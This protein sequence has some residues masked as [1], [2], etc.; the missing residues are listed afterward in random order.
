MLKKLFHGGTKI[1][2]PIEFTHQIHIDKDLN[3]SFDES[4]DPK[5]VF[6]K[7]KVIGKGGFGTVSQ[8]A[9]I[10]SMTIL[11]GK[12]INSNLVNESSKLELE[13]E[14]QLM[15]E[16]DSP[17]TVRYY[18]SVA[19][20]G[21]LMILME[22]CDKGSLRD[23]L[24]KREQ[25]LSEDQISLV[26]HDLLMGLNLIHKKHRIVHR[27]IKAA[28]LLL[29][30]KGDIKIADFGVSRRF[31]ASGTCHT[32]SMVGT[33]YWMAPEVIS[34][35]SYSFPA[36]I[37]SVGVTAIELAEGSPP[38]V[39]FAPTK[40]MIEIAVKGFP[41]YRFPTMHSPEFCD[42]VSHCLETNPNN[43]WTIDELLEHQFIKRAERLNRM[44]V[45]AD[46]LDDFSCDSD[47]KL[48][49]NDQSDMD[50]ISFGE[51][52]NDNNY[53]S[54]GLS[55]AR[56]ITISD[57]YASFEGTAMMMSRRF[58]SSLSINSPF[59]QGIN[60]GGNDFDTSNV[61]FVSDS[62]DL[63]SGNNY[64]SFRE[65]SINS[66]STQQSAMDS[67]NMGSNSPFLQ[68]NN[69]VD[70]FM[71]ENNSNFMSNDDDDDEISF[72][73]LPMDS[74]NMNNSPFPHNDNN[75]VDSFMLENNENISNELSENIQ[76]KENNIP[77]Q[78]EENQQNSVPKTVRFSN[79]L[80]T[81]NSAQ[82][83]SVNNLPDKLFVKVSRVMSNKIPFIPIKIGS[84]NDAEVDTLYQKPNT[85]FTNLKSKKEL[86]DNDGIINP[87]G[88]LYSK[89]FYYSFALVILF[90]T[91]FFIKRNGFIG[92]I[93]L[94]YLTVIFKILF[95][96][97][98][99]KQDKDNSK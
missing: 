32:M 78:T 28:N 34:G 10:P 9:H 85:T 70:S 71:L 54:D 57:N 94:C 37:W 82:T 90:L 88:A 66:F 99:R 1:T 13:H 58:N 3:W 16:V 4:L 63:R 39:E 69:N 17:Y 48:S 81:R 53:I 84:N 61:N 56:N 47:R 40:A 30:S 62:S 5:T 60:R 79:T 51:S 52:S 26:M 33:P 65:N 64:I 49:S 74:F 8:I 22:Y 6:I 92:L 38:Y 27:D 86:F 14:I 93:G 96:K 25:V 68:D 75:N 29:T 12:L 77:Q 97:D 24:D 43:R 87:I 72:K 80:N 67:F 89:K 55:S 31:E 35:I 36:D 83:I 21:T 95:M 59:E 23:I 44:E 15:R 98:K 46:L 76:Q 50:S 45:L 41:G 2:D 18:G 11:A 73:S 20:E 19:Y 7:L 91:F 42:F